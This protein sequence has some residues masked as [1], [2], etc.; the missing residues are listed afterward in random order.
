MARRKPK[1]Q[2]YAKR[3]TKRDDDICVVVLLIRRKGDSIARKYYLSRS[4]EGLT[5]SWFKSEA[6][7]FASADAAQDAASNAPPLPAFLVQHQ[8]SLEHELKVMSANDPTIS[9]ARPGENLS[10]VIYHLHKHGQS[11]RRELQQAI[12]E[13][14]EREGECPRNH[15]NTL[16]KQWL[17]AG[18]IRMHGR[19]KPKYEV[20]D[21]GRLWL[22]RYELPKDYALAELPTREAVLI[23]CDH[24]EDEGKAACEVG[25]KIAD[26][27]A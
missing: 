10:V 8:D 14:Q 15:W 13:S 7:E 24:L 20:T 27:G 21:F 19:Q 23:A 18:F 22:V 25:R 6:Y 3:Y 26:L 11:T 12:W 2:F 4:Q 17:D 5:W 9:P 1:T 16:F